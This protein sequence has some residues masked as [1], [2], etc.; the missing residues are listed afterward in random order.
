MCIHE[1]GNLITSGMVVILFTQIATF[2]HVV[3][4][5]VNTSNHFCICLCS[6][7]ILYNIIWNTTAVCLYTILNSQGAS[8]LNQVEV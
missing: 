4:A 3:L 5:I 1:L 7:I 6:C 2:W 8:R